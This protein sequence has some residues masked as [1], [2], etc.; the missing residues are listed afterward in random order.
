MF[1]PKLAAVLGTAGRT[2]E[3]FGQP[4]KL[5]QPRSNGVPGLLST[6]ANGSRVLA[7]QLINSRASPAQEADLLLKLLKLPCKSSRNQNGEPSAEVY[8]IIPR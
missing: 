1:P 4:R 6:T 2:E 8:C 3:P 7:L 5:M